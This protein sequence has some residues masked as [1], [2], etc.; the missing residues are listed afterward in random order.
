MAEN[1][2]KNKQK[3]G[4]A[5]ERKLTSMDEEQD[6][7]DVYTHDTPEPI[8]RSS[9]ISKGEHTSLEI[10]REAVED[11]TSESDPVQTDSSVNPALAE[12]TIDTHG[13]HKCTADQERD[14]YV[15]NAPLRESSSAFL[16]SLTSASNF[17]SPISSPYPS[18]DSLQSFPVTKDPSSVDIITMR[19]T[20]NRSQNTLEPPQTRQDSGTVDSSPS[21][22]STSTRATAIAKQGE[23]PSNPDRPP[24]ASHY[25]PTRHT[26]LRANARS[27]NIQE[28]SHISLSPS[29]SY[30]RHPFGP[31]FNSAD[32]TPTESADP[33]SSSFRRGRAEED[34]E[35]VYNRTPLLQPMEFPEPKE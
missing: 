17:S 12:D 7:T 5:V 32:H 16:A 18:S 6:I 21:S 30:R 8:I 20:G 34:S 13:P 19:P 23:A 26:S 24:T 3:E 2:H 4:S 27:I 22:S 25:V 29:R 9:D 14:F 35:E 1:V 33:F 10:K 11:S 28:D 15:R 31:G